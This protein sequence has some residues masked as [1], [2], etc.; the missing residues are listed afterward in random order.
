MIRTESSVFEASALKCMVSL[1]FFFYQDSTTQCTDTLEYWMTG[2]FESFHHLSC[3]RIPFSFKFVKKSSMPLLFVSRT[4]KRPV[5]WGVVC[6]H[7]SAKAFMAIALLSQSSASLA[8]RAFFLEWLAF[9]RTWSVGYLW[10]DV[11]SCANSLARRDFS[12]TMATST[13]EVCL[14]VW[15][16]ANGLGRWVA[17]CLGLH[18]FVVSTVLHLPSTWWTL[19]CHATPTVIDFALVHRPI[20]RASKA[21][22]TTAKICCCSNGIFSFP[23]SAWNVQFSKDR[24]LTLPLILLNFRTTPS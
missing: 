9:A 12:S 15:R 16:I 14:W 6:T 10:R 8:T 2:I 17:F 13:L 7:S 21:M 1:L 5:R 20:L 22:P 4:E 18:D 11:V 3:F 19:H 24:E 23:R